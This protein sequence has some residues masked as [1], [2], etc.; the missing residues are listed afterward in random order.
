MLEVMFGEVTAQ[1]EKQH[2]L[3][4]WGRYRREAYLLGVLIVTIGIG[5]RA[6]STKRAGGG[7][8]PA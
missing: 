2:P 8:H 6:R 5:K 7:R 1:N 4:I 3:S